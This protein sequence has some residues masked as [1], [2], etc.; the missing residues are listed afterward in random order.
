MVLPLAWAQESLRIR[1]TEFAPN[2]FQKE[3]RWGG[4]DVELAEALIREAGF[5]SM[6]LDLPWSRALGYLQSG[7]LDVMMNVSRTPDREAFMYF[8]G[9]ERL[10]RRVLV[11]RREQAG[12]PLAGMD[13]L[14]KAAAQARSTIGIQKDARYSEAFDRRLATDSGFAQ[15]FDPVV[16]GTVLPRKTLAGR[17]LGFIEDEY[18]VAYQ[19]RNNPDFQELAIHPLALFADPVY[20][21][22][23]K[24]IDPDKL[25]RLESAFQRLEKS[26]VLARIRAR[27]AAQK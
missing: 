26:G 11:V 15:Y 22:V 4:L 18:F 25:R 9:P 7:E 3:G 12:L 1:V 6:Y 10:S 16:Q 2:Y 8:I 24:A 13:D 20:F 19:L 23:S 27:W 21:G 5:Q 17:N 14:V